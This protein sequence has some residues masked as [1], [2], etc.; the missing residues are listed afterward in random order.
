MARLG[1]LE[2]PFGKAIKYSHNQPPSTIIISQHRLTCFRAV[3][4]RFGLCGDAEAQ[5]K[6]IAKQSKLFAKSERPTF[7]PLPP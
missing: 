7:P 5:S 3:S 1:F 2:N 4:S 6:L